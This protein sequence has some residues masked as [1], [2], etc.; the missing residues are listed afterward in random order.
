MSDCQIAVLQDVPAVGRYV[1][2]S[3]VHRQI[4]AVRQSLRQLCALT[5]GIQMLVGIGPEL[6]QLLGADVPGLHGFK[7]L[8]GLGVAVPAT[9]AALCCWL[10]GEDA[11]VLLHLTRQ[12]Q[13]VLAPG[14]RQEQVIDA[15]RYGR[16]LDGSSFMTVQQWVHD[17]DAFEGMT[18]QAQDHTVG[19]SRV[20]NDELDDAPASAHVK[21]TAQESFSPAA[22]VLRRSMSW[23]C[24][25]QSGLVFVAF[26]HSFD[27]FEVLMRHMVGLDDGVVDALF[28]IS[29]PVTGANFWCPPM[30]RGHLDLRQLGL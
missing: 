16:G 29:R 22:Y 6:V 17:L 26:G 24:G 10:R 25:A 14:F 19:R 18:G 23:T 13:R 15:F 30:H 4:D 5:D 11:G 3:L 21:R 12:L 27:A 28:D 20:S 2:F 8:S 9:P 1:Y 7:A